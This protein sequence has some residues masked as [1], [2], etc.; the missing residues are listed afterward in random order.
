[1]RSH[2][3]TK[4][5]S[6]Y[7]DDELH[8]RELRLVESHISECSACR[9]RLHGLRLV[10]GELQRVPAAETPPT[11]AA[12]IATEAG[13]RWGPGG[14][15]VDRLLGRR[16]LALLR[17]MI[18]LSAITAGAMGI[19]AMLAAYG[20]AQ[21]ASRT[22][23]ETAAG[24]PAPAMPALDTAALHALA[25]GVAA[26]GEPESDES[27]RG[28]LDGD[29]PVASPVEVDLVVEAPAREQSSDVGEVGEDA[30]LRGALPGTE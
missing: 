11:L 3:A 22:T 21:D 15:P 13:M 7:I 10:V 6:A 26:A 20:A 28:R 4:R 8:D 29:D 5:L 17:D 16:G 24:E 14:P 1:M 19:I 2:L 23:R 30:G 25:P 12:S 9:D 18:Q 27:D